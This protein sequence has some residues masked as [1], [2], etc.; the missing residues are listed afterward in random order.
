[1]TDRYAV[2]GNPI[3]HSKS[4]LLQMTFARQ[5]GQDMVYERI[6][7]SR[8]SFS[9]HIEDFRNQGGKGLNITVPFK[10]EAFDLADER[11]PRS[12]MAG[13]TNTYLFRDNGEIL[14]D[15]TDGVGI[16]RDITGNLGHDFRNRRI[17]ILGAGGAVRGIILPILEERPREIVV[18]NRTPSTAQELVRAFSP[19]AGDSVISGGDFPGTCGRFDIIINGTSSSLSNQTLQLNQ[20]IWG[21]E[22][23]AYDMV[24]Q[25]RPTQF[26]ELAQ[27]CGCGKTSDGLGMLVEQGAE[28]FYLWRGIRPDT[29]P[30][31]RMLRSG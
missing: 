11:T 6:L 31:I 13:A 29:A 23:L 10:V 4:P 3:D 25:N 9:R 5:T 2:I 12:R 26:M 18:A 20:D 28:S 27:S 21:P 17:L 14:G 7:G 8:D 1:M 22:S 30:V 16:V 15:N 24:Y 19:F